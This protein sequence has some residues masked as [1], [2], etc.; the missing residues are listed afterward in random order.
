MVRTTRLMAPYYWHHQCQCGAGWAA[1]C[2]ARQGGRITAGSPCRQRRRRRTRSRGDRHKLLSVNLFAPRGRRSRELSYTAGERV[3][4]TLL[5]PRPPASTAPLHHAA[6]AHG[7][8]A[9]PVTCGLRR[10]PART[11]PCPPSEVQNDPAPLQAVSSWPAAS[12]TTPRL[13]TAFLA[14]PAHGRGVACGV[15]PPGRRRAVRRAVQL[16][17]D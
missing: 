13:A 16:G 7:A 11:A 10:A 3:N 6:P 12:T 2:C 1:G 9:W 8:G 4:F 14:A 5:K 15:A 17:A